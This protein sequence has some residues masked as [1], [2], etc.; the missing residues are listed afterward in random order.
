MV[1]TPHWAPWLALDHIY[2]GGLRG[3]IV[4]AIENGQGDTSSNLELSV[5][6][7]NTTNTFEKGKNPY[8]LPPAKGRLRSLAFVRDGKFT[9]RCIII[10]IIIN[11]Y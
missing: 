9:L 8:I 4:T 2:T 6:N 10:I 11:M 1:V 5:C 3:V 7:L